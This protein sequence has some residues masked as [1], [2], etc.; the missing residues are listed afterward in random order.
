MRRSN[1][2]ALIFLFCWTK[3]L[4]AAVSVTVVSKSVAKIILPRCFIFSDSFGRALLGV[5]A[6]VNNIPGSQ[7]HFMTEAVLILAGLITG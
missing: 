5:T 3:D 2:A 7:Q 6:E 4:L 1:D